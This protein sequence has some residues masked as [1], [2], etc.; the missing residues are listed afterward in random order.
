MGDVTWPQLFPHQQPL[1]HA[2]ATSFAWLLAAGSCWKAGGWWLAVE[3][4]Y[5]DLTAAG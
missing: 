2:G 5:Q 3:C 1:F 4:V